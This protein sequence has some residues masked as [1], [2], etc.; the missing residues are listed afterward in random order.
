MFIS[1]DSQVW[2]WQP[3]PFGTCV[4]PVPNGI[5]TPLPSISQ[6]HGANNLPRKQ[7]TRPP[8]SSAPFSHLTGSAQCHALAL[9]SRAERTELRTH[10]PQTQTTLSFRVAQSENPTKPHANGTS[11]ETRHLSFALPPPQGA[12]EAP[13][14]IC[15]SR[16]QGTERSHVFL[17]SSNL[18]RRRKD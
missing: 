6:I 2:W 5:P 18:L 13:L 7:Q 17:R 4:S 12:E 8:L 15:Q 14:S 1:L 10:I 3:S 16:P 11:D 9:R